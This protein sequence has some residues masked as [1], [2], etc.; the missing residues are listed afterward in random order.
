VPRCRWRRERDPAGLVRLLGT[1]DTLALSASDAQRLGATSA[2]QSRSRS[3]SGNWGARDDGRRHTAGAGG[4]GL[5]GLAITDIAT[6]QE[7]LGRIGEIERID[8]MLTTP[9]PP[10]WRDALPAGLRLQPAAQRSNAL[11]QMT[12]A[13]HTNLTAMSLLAMLVGGFI[14]YNTMTFAVLQ[15]RPLLGTLRMLG[16]TR[17]QLFLLVLTEA[18]VLALI[19]AVIGML[20]GIA[21]GAG[22]V[23]LVTRTINDIYF[24]LSVRSLHVDSTVAA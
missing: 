18:L 10:R 22:L 14:V 17:S 24:Q 16:V 1:P 20:I 21:V 2:T 6:A 12:R 7:V 4:Q 15:R 3:A 13:F 19:G 8:L 23:Q 5:A 11:E 9:R